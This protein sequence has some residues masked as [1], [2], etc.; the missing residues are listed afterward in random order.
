MKHRKAVVFLAVKASLKAQSFISADSL[1]ELIKLG[2]PLANVSNE[3][4]HAT[5]DHFKK[6]LVT[7]IDI[8]VELVV[9][10]FDCGKDSM[11][12]RFRL[13]MVS[14]LGLVK[15]HFTMIFR[16]CLYCL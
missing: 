12:A 9:T 13:P 11:H 1:E 7:V 4:L 6:K 10:T 15:K 2:R 16:T 8:V 5:I 3:V 14:L